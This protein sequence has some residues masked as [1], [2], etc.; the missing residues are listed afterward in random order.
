MLL[1]LILLFVSTVEMANKQ[2]FFWS[3]IKMIDDNFISI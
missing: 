3:N 2:I 1:S